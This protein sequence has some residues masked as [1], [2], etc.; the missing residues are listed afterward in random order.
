MSS[1]ETLRAHAR[2][3]FAAGLKA[4]DPLDAIRKHVH[5]DG[6]QLRVA[7]RLYELS[8]F[9]HIYVT[10]CG[11]AAARMALALEEL[12]DARITGG[13]VV[14]KY[15][16]GLPLRRID[17]I[18]AG[19]P[20]PDQAGL[21]GARQ[22]MDL[23]A[24]AGE[25]DLVFFLVSGGGSALL[26]SPADGLTLEDK[27]RTTEALLKCGATI[28][29]VNAVRKHLSKVKGG[30][31][32]QLAAPATLITLA[33]SDVVGDSLED[34]A[35]GPTVAG[36]STYADCLQIIR[37]YDLREQV[38]K[39][40]IEFLERGARGEIDETPKSL[41]GAFQNIQNIIVGS[42][43]MALEAAKRKAEALGYP[44]MI[45]SSAVEGESRAVAVTHAALLKEIRRT[46]MPIGRPACVLSGGETTVT[47]RGAGLG[48]RN[49]EF[50]L[51]AAIAIEGISGAVILS[52][53]TDGT[54]GPTDAA[55]AIVDGSTIPRG[56][57]KGLDAEE[58]LNRSDSY[59]YL[60]AISDLL[61][62]GPTFTNVM[63][64]QVMLIA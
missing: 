32:A 7:G 40:V 30:R 21:R 1:I 8:K 56:R 19:H 35:S 25:K 37:R 64:L 3:I 33:L 16:H 26:P 47:V 54:D 13:I 5:V 29:E 61:Q 34:I 43:R 10:G 51:A 52:A 45:L 46:H 17:V 41:S 15:D 39:S 6:S 58:F 2:A 49:Q 48:G 11:K 27:Q 9:H 18:E 50:A 57:A 12:L 20:V 38:P 22:V 23:M 24:A 62:T 14:V 28:G 36:R 60:Q 53:G 55:G 4:A 63:D 59:H 31:L 44:T 42:N